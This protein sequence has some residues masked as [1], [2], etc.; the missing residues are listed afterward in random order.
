LKGRT[1]A[2]SSPALLS[3]LS[4]P[5]CTLNFHTSLILICRYSRW[6]K[7]DSPEIV[8]DFLKEGWLETD[9]EFIQS[10]VDNEGKGWNGEQ[11]WGFAEVDGKRYHVRR[12]VVKKGDET[13]KVRLVY[14]WHGK[15]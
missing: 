10:F 12:V 14:D 3:T 15:K 8:D 6:I 11:I 7:I 5:S 2:T 1:Y 13:L 4:T 9:G